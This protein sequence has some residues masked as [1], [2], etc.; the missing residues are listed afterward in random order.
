ME[1]LGGSVAA[2]LNSLKRNAGALKMSKKETAREYRA[3]LLFELG[4]RSNQLVTRVNPFDRNRYRVEKLV[5]P[6]G[7]WPQLQQYQFNVLT[8][9]GLEPHHSIVDIGCG[10]ITV[11]LKL[12]SYLDRGNYVGLDSLSEPLVEAYRAVVEHSLAEKNP[13]LVCSSTFGKDE[14][15]DRQFDYVWVSQLSYHLDEVQT[16]RLF[17][18]LRS[19]MS[20]VV[21]SCSAARSALTVSVRS[22]SAKRKNA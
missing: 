13:T 10:P 5:G 18:Q 9:L 3:R 20:A 8:R 21:L 19:M 12:I 2:I 16:A 17:E 11:G 15:G 14:L 7:V 6:L 22:L 4:R 1:F